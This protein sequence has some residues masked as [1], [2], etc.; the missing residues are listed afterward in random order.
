MSIQLEI[1]V[2]FRFGLLL[3]GRSRSSEGGTALTRNC[4]NFLSIPPAARLTAARPRNSKVKVKVPAEENPPNAV[5]CRLQGAWYYVSPAKTRNESIRV[6]RVNPPVVVTVSRLRR[7]TASPRARS[8]WARFLLPSL[9]FSLG[10]SAGR[11]KSPTLSDVKS[12]RRFGTA[13]HRTPR[14]MRR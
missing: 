12:S 14:N 5:P 13:W 10:V 7:R 2:G 6:R 1:F 9:T 3:L 11:L 8:I 4:N